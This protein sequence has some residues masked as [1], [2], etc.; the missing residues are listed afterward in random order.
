MERSQAI[1][2]G[3]GDAGELCQACMRKLMD[4]T[5]FEFFCMAEEV[6]DGAEINAAAAV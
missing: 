3:G 4:L 2:R 1:S 5:A 6:L